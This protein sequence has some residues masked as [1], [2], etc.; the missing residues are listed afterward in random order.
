VRNTS[1]NDRTL[2]FQYCIKH[3]GTLVEIWTK[4]KTDVVNKFVD[5]WEKKVPRYAEHYWIGKQTNKF[6]NLSF[7][8]IHWCSVVLGNRST[9]MK[10]FSRRLPDYIFIAFLIQ[11]KIS[12]KVEV[13]LRPS[14]L[15]CAHVYL[16][17][18]NTFALM[19]MLQQNISFKCFMLTFLYRTSIFANFQAFTK[20]N[21][22]EN[23]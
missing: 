16:Y 6:T 21:S 13:S 19:F 4:E 18:N 12:L 1:Q 9:G 15:F 14:L 23:L 11:T 5:D 20:S 10:I 17:Y 2:L 7:S 3:N 8:D 22:L